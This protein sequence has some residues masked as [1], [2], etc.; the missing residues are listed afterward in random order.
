MNI[1][2]AEKVQ[3]TMSHNMIGHWD[4]IDIPLKSHE[5][6]V[7]F[8]SAKKHGGRRRE[9]YH[10]TSEHNPLPPYHSYPP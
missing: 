5:P 10:F 3:E 2:I 6:A 1:G 8:P 9:K 4:S 7:F